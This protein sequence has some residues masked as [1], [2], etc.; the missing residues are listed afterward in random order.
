MATTGMDIAFASAAQLLDLYR[1]EQISPV[2]VTRAILERIERLNGQLHAYL[3]V[4]AEGALKAARAADAAYAAGNAGSLAGVPLSIKDLVDVR[5]LPTTFGSR[6]YRDYI[7]EE[8]AYSVARLRAAGAVILGKTNTP[9]FGS[10]PTNENR[11]GDSARNPWD[12]RRSPGGSSGGAAAAVAAGLGALGLGTDFGGSIRIPA[13]MCGVFGFKP[14][15]GR[16][17]RDTSFNLTGE[18][19]SHEG[20][21]SRTVLDSALYLD[22]CAGPD[23]R[24]RFSQLGPPPRFVAGLEA[25]PSR[26][27]VAWSHDLG[28]ASVS[29]EV[30]LLCERAVASLHGRLGE[31]REATPMGVQAGVEAWKV[32]GAAGN[33]N[34]ERTMYVRQQPDELTAA[35]RRGLDFAE[36]TTLAQYF[37]ALRGLRRWREQATGFFANYDLLLTPT[38]PVPAVPDNA[39]ELLIDGQRQEGTLGLIQFTA[40]FNATGQPAASIPCGITDAGLPVGLQVVAPFGADLLLMQAARAIEQTLPWTEHRPAL[41]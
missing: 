23:P 6:V 34:A 26:L 5:G 16:I 36:T 12:T 37:D 39:T 22:V 3:H 19:F 8:D 31:I 24:D 15:L 35:V 13:S 18:F 40:P 14:T 1:S 7:A 17:A 28:Y 25:L 29:T 9:E 4:D 21:L 41:A 30:R 33:Y 20:P 2:E 11:L 10:L 38:L 27:R 32:V